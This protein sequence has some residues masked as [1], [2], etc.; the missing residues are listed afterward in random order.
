M[1]KQIKIEAACS[2]F[3]EADYIFEDEFLQE[4]EKE[5]FVVKIYDDKDKERKNE[6]VVFSK[7]H[8][9]LSQNIPV[10]D[11]LGLEIESEIYAA[12]SYK[13]KKIYLRKY[14]IDNVDE[15]QWEESKQNLSAVIAL[16][17]SNKITNSAL[18]ALAYKAN[19]TWREIRLIKAIAIYED[20]LISILSEQFIG[21]TLVKYSDLSKLFVKYFQTKFD[22]KIK[23]RE[24]KLKELEKK[25]FEKIKAVKNISEDRVLRIFF[26]ILKAQVR[27]NYY[28]ND[29]QIAFKVDVTK[30]MGELKGVQPAIE[31]FVYHPLFAGVHA[32]ILA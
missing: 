4:L 5:G 23:S 24:L 29:E 21:K 12:L 11:N 14:I 31:A 25:I 8:T 10:L 3:N 2:D 30:L 27:T 22:P 26:N 1:D 20:Q 19:L 15:K 28:F 13:N 32:F 7:E 17:F 16:A 9:T 6:I 18:N